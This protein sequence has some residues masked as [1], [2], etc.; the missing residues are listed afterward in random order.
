MSADSYD[1][2]ET[3][4][5][6]NE[7]RE[8]LQQYKQQQAA[9][10]AAEHTST[11]ELIAAEEQPDPDAPP[12][13]RETYTLEFRGHEFE[14]Y[15][16]GDAALTATELANK[17]SGVDEDGEV[18]ANSEAAAFVY[19]TLGEKGVRTNEAYW[20]QYDLGSEDGDGVM[21]LFSELAD[22]AADVDEEEMEEIEEFR[23]DE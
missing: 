15:E 11:R 13:L 7:K 21:A 20:R 4:E 6:L 16:I 5:E 1:N 18:E 22:A 19:E 23:D 3:K 12:D 9:E 17:A 2:P 8:R 10:E 14:F